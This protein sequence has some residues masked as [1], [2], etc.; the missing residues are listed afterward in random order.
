MPAAVLRSA[1]AAT[2]FLSGHSQ[3]TRKENLDILDWDDDCGALP[4][5]TFFP[6]QRTSPDQ[7]SDDD[8]DPT[9]DSLFEYIFDVDYVVAEGGLHRA[10][11][12]RWW[13]RELRRLRAAQRL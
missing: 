5:I 7:P 12:L 13:R 9:D 11:Q 6:R 1:P 3:N 2:D 4:D 8:A 10:E